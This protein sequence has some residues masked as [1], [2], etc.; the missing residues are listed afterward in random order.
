MKKFFGFTTM[1][2]AGAMLI[3]GMLVSLTG[4][5]FAAQNPIS[6]I[7][8]SQA[9]GEYQYWLRDYNGYL[10]VFGKESESP[11]LIFQ[12]FTNRLCKTESAYGIMKSWLLGLKILSAENKNLYFN[13]FVTNRN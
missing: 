6:S 2:V 8:Q 12:V 7:S 11:E 1:S 5:N 9:S 3:S 13:Q 4:E 10:A